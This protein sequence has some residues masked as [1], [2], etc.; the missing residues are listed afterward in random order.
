VGDEGAETW[1]AY[2]EFSKK[3]RREFANYFGTVLVPTGE[4]CR[5]IVEAANRKMNALADSA[6]WL[7]FVIFHL[8]VFMLQAHLEAVVMIGQ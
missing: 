7:Q 6:T 3:V 4:L 2:P 1:W 8:S 5:D